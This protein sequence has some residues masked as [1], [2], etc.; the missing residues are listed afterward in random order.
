MSR[1]I[2]LIRIQQL[3][4]L[5]RVQATY[6]TVGN[7]FIFKHIIISLLEENL[8]EKKR[9]IFYNVIF[10][11]FNGIILLL[12]HFK[13]LNIKSRDIRIHRA[14]HERYNMLFELNMW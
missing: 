9:Q 10:K 7:Y 8:E 2:Y 11:L 5:K 14:I 3:Y 4:A 6:C 1:T 13:C 12:F